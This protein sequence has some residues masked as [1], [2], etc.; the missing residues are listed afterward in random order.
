MLKDSFSVPYVYE[1]L[2]PFRDWPASPGQLLCALSI[3][4]KTSLILCESIH[5][6]SSSL[7]ESARSLVGCDYPTALGSR[8]PLD[9]WSRFTPL[10]FC[11]TMLTHKAVP[12]LYRF[13][14]L[15]FWFS[16]H[17]HPLCTPYTH[18]QGS[19]FKQLQV[20]PYTAI[21]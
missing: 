2:S 6:Q 3:L 15:S 20:V 8:P 13:Y 12:I 21:Q 10:V 5:L 17:P 14:S 7:A 18:T 1:V 4:H 19:G 11:M 16:W 9:L